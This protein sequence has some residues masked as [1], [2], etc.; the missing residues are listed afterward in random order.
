[1]CTFAPATGLPC[2]STTWPLTPDVVS[3]ACTL[4]MDNSTD[5]TN[6]GRSFLFNRVFI[7]DRLSIVSSNNGPGRDRW[8]RNALLPKKFRRKFPRESAQ[9][10]DAQVLTPP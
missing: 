9:E 10:A 4:D 7:M 2:A 8:R 3:W 1:M 6:S 5:A